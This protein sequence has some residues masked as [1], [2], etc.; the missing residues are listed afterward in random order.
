[1]QLSIFMA[2]I[3]LMT[4][5]VYRDYNEKTG[6][7]IRLSAKEVFENDDSANLLRIFGFICF[8]SKL[9]KAFDA[10]SYSYFSCFHYFFSIL[11][12][13]A[14]VFQWEKRL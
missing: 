8:H 14:K 10:P 13:S 11:L 4:Y 7:H 6:L 2:Y 5:I 9:P 1:M 3:I 12:Y